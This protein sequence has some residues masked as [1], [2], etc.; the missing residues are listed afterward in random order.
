LAEAVG[1][2]KQR[3]VGRDYRIMERD[4]IDRQ[5][6]RQSAGRRIAATV[7]EDVSFGGVFETPRSSTLSSVR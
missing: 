3:T 1:S 4:P 2:R 6:Q 5:Q 7:P